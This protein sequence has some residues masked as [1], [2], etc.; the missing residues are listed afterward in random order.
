MSYDFYYWF[1]MSAAFIITNGLGVGLMLKTQKLLLST[2]VS[3]I[4]NLA[5]F[6]VASIWWA[7]LFEGFARMFGLF[8]FGV[9][10]VNIEVLLFFGLFIMKKKST[11]PV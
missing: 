9:A 7:S 2:L 1:I 11:P 8:G 4:V 10:F 3:F 6:V 5:I